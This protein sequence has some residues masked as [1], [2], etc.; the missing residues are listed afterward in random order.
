M[1]ATKTQNI[2]LLILFYIR[3]NHQNNINNYI[4]KNISM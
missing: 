1:Q 4:S 3:G 2:P